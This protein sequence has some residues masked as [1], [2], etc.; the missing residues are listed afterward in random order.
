MILNSFFPNFKINSLSMAVSEFTSKNPA[1]F[2][3]ASDFKFLQPL[4]DHVDVIRNELLKLLEMKQ[5]PEWLRTFPDYVKSESFKAWKVFSFNFFSM[6]FPSH[7]ALCP[8]TAELIYSI[9]E[10][11]SCDFSFME[12][13]THILPHKGYSK[14]V[15]RCHIPLIVPDEELC[16]IRVGNETRHWKEGE[17]MVFD[18]SFDHEAWNKSDAKRVVLMFD[19]PNPAWGYTAY[20]ISKYKIEHIDDPFLLSLASKQQWQEYFER[21]YLLFEGFQ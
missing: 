5:D 6:K 20:E 8:Q 14:M 15:L 18:D 9:P 4:V 2:Y 3:N 13:H 12:P 10:I 16:A 11:M 7:A 21:G 1:Y 19:I 17:L